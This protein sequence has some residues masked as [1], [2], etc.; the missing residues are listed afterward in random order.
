MTNKIKFAVNDKVKHPLY[1]EGTITSIK[2]NSYYPYVVKFKNGFVESYSDYS[3][4][5]VK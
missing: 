5:K 4:T 3:L 2:E 1:G